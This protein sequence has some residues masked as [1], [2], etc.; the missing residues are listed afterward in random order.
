MELSKSYLTAW[1]LTQSYRQV[2]GGDGWPAAILVGGERS[3]SRRGGFGLPDILNKA[4]DVDRF[5]SSRAITQHQKRL[6]TYVYTNLVYS[7]MV[8]A[9]FPDGSSSEPFPDTLMSDYPTAIRFVDVKASVDFGH[10]WSSYDDE[11]VKEYCRAFRR[12][13]GKVLESEHVRI[14]KR[15][16]DFLGL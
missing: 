11:A 5:L 2:S 9:V 14:A 6:V 10:S 4:L 1:G 16:V 3:K 7:R 8:K 15:L 13:V 12:P